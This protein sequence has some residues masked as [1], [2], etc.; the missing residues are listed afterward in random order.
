MRGRITRSILFVAGLVVLGLGV[1]LAI[2]V[3]RFYEDRA[4]VDLQRRAAE[5]TAELSLPLTRDNVTRAAEETDSPRAFSVYDA[6]G[7]RLYGGGPVAGDDPVRE[8]LRGNA[9]SEHARDELVVATP[10]T[11][12]GTERVVGAL[13]VTQPADVVAGQARRAWL[14]MGGVV[15]AAFA[16]AVAIAE[17]QARRLSEPIARLAD[18]AVGLGRGDFAARLAPSGIPEVDTVAAAL[19]DSAARLAELLAR[20]R[21]FSADVAHQLRTPLAGLRLRLE[22]AL[23]ADDRRQAVEG[24]LAEVDRLEATVEHLLALARDARQVSAPLAVSRLLRAVDD[25]WQPRFG[26]VGRALTV[27]DGERLPTVNASDVSIGQVLDVLIDNALRHGDGAV[28][29][30]ARAATGGLVIEVDDE[31]PGIPD[32]RL[33]TVFDRHE[34]SG[35]GIGLALA[36]TITEAEGGRLLAARGQPPCFHLILP[37]TGS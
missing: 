3:Q 2:V 19:D 33:A 12:Q 10:I 22:H 23:R 28:G 32:D 37:V 30:R 21:S 7:R 8:A 18:Q 34:G 29:V 17:S 1:P 14:L 26:H 13:R 5:A 36:R 9:S 31:G 24:A 6:T 25:R 20:E 4:V 35:N 15:G 11:D 27:H 16:M